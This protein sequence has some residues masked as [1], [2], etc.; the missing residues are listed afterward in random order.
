MLD[1]YAPEIPWQRADTVIAD[2]YKEIESLLLE[3]HLRHGVSLTDFL[4]Q[5]Q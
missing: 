4:Y 2:L 1:V 3:T 5:S